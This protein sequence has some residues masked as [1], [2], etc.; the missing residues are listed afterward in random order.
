MAFNFPSNPTANQQYIGPNGVVYTYDGVKWSGN[1]VTTVI[2][3]NTTIT[4]G[5]SITIDVD[6]TDIAYQNNT[7]ASGTLTINSPVG[8]PVDCQKLTIKIKSQNVQT[9]AWNAVFTGSTDSQL[10]TATSGAGKIDYIGFMY[11]ASESK[12]HMVAKNFGF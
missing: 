6:T 7:Q 4:N 9:F 5:T 1:I 12:W 2:G 11:S 8:T 3:N 10:P